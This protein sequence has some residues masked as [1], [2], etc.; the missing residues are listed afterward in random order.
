M[1]PGGM[2]TRKRPGETPAAPPAPPPVAAAVWMHVSAINLWDRNPRKNDPVVPSI[3]ASIRE[4]GFPSAL[5]VYP[6][7]GNM[8]TAGHTRMKAMHF[9]LAEEPT[10]TLAG[11]PGP[12]FVPVR[13]HTFKSPAQAQAYALADN[14]LAENA[15]WDEAALHDIAEDIMAEDGMGMLS[16]A[17]FDDEEIASMLAGPDPGDG[18]G[19]GTDDGSGPKT[20][21]TPSGSQHGS[22]GGEGAPD[23]RLV[24]LFL[25]EAEHA[26]LH[27]LLTALGPRLGKTEQG[28]I[29]LHALRALAEAT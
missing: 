4:F 17:G 26:E 1:I 23:M 14:R 18:G 9:I 8:L 5:I 3:V 12:G 27:A 24:Q 16:L 19:G 25:P 11:A 29:V 6:E 15:E 22:A 28:A 7:G 13:L 20:P 10:F 2:V 21:P